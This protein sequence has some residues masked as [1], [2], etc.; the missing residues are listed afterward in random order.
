MAATPPRQFVYQM[1]MR[2]RAVLVLRFSGFSFIIKELS[3]ENEE[4]RN[5][6]GYFLYF[7]LQG[8]PE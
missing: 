3:Q 2:R 5:Y 7:G 1:L 4:H 6:A 8:E